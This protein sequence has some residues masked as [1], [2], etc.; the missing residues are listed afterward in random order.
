M[1]L[2]GTGNGC[3]GIGQ[4]PGSSSG[5]CNPRKFSEKIALLTQ[6]QAED[7]AAF[8]EVMMDIT[9][10]RIQ[11]QR[12]RQAR[13]LGTYYGG[14]LP[15]VNQLGRSTSGVQGQLPCSPDNGCPTR[16]HPMAERAQGEGRLNFPVRPNRRNTDNSPYCS[17]HLSPPLEPSWRRNLSSSS[18]VD[19]SHLMHH[20]FTALN[21]TNS[22]S[23]LH[24]SMRNTHT[25]DQQALTSR[26]RHRVF[27]YPVPPIEENV[28]EE[29]KSLR[30]TKKLPALPTGIKSRKVPGI[31][32]LSSP[33][34][35][36]SALNV[37]SPL[38]ASGSLP[39]LSSLHLPS[40]QPVGVDSHKPTACS[41][42]HLPGT[43]SHLGARDDEFPLPGLS[44]SL[45]GSYSNPLLQSFHSNPNI[46]SSLRSHSLSSSLNSTSLNLSLSNSSLQS[47][48]SNQS[49]QSFLSSS[50]L[51]GLSLQCATSHCSYSSGIGGSRTCSSSS[52]S[53]S[54]RPTSQ[55]QVPSSR[56]QT[57]L[58]PLVVPTGGESRWLQSKQFSPV[59]SPKLSSITQGVLLNTN[60]LPQESRPPG[61][62]HCQPQH[63][64]PPAAQQPMHGGLPQQQHSLTEG[65]QQPSQELKKTPL[66]Q[67]KSRHQQ[68][69]AH[70]QQQQQQDQQHPQ[71]QLP[72]THNLQQLQYHHRQPYQHPNQ[73]YQCQ[74]QHVQ[75]EGQNLD[76]K[77]QHQRGS[78]QCENPQQQHLHQSQEEQHQRQQQQKQQKQVYQNL[79][80]QQQE[81]QRQQHQQHPHQQQYQQ[82]AYQ[83]QPQQNQALRQDE[84]QHQLQQVQPYHQQQHE[85][86]QWHPKCAYP[87]AQSLDLN[88]QNMSNP[89]KVPT[90]QMTRKHQTQAQGRSWAHQK[91]QG[92]KDQIESTK[93]S[94]QMNSLM[95]NNP[96]LYNDSS[97]RNHLQHESYMGLHLTPSQT[98]AL[99][100]QLE[101]LSKEPLW[102]DSGPQSVEVKDGG[103]Y[104]GNQGP[105]ISLHCQ[106]QTSVD[107]HNNLMM[108]KASYDDFSGVLP[109][110]G[111]DADT[112]TLHNPLQI[113]P[114]D[115]EELNI[116]AGGDMVE[117]TVKGHCSN[118]LR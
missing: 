27:P 87:P 29:G 64:G 33:D 103:V 90:M 57:P 68:Q 7:T 46:Q 53:C 4:R 89:R 111:F 8:Q 55:T 109:M 110:L 42:D 48:P 59:G 9:S 97:I 60:Q 78:N 52:L 93:I 107:C 94:S 62:H 10:T 43:P 118:L 51:S 108:D 39:N 20:P 70:Q 80:Q 105:H 56:R 21:R 113:D 81:K 26:N 112:F 17:V 98:Q 85:Q 11:V 22:D 79:P 31:N 35:Q 14:S 63:E 74:I 73:L 30:N 36:F 91:V 117:D 99:S 77:P 25:G 2:A 49:L 102:G 65:Q 72:Q 28:L 67:E 71:Q 76:I 101:Q 16:L 32:I 19:K 47:S 18:P 50:S 92:Q 12:V 45:Q 37:P 41:T 38:N 100:Q 54:P 82:Q 40:P 66:H 24:T 23:A 115:L 86:H 58:S 95:D 75:T 6:R 96:G 1:F 116:L 104:C 13:S 84:M 34:Q 61:Y 83:R 5:S 3:C 15:N 69:G 88:G 114:L 44:L 106:N